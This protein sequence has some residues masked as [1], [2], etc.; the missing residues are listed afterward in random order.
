MGLESFFTLAEKAGFETIKSQQEK[1]GLSVILG[2]CGV[3]L[4]E[5]THFYTA[6]AREGNLH[7]LAFTQED[8]SNLEAPISLFSPEATY[9]IGSILSVIE[10]PDMP[11]RY[12]ESTKLKV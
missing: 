6:F 2:G 12:L 8:K 10:R 4:E 9:M 11:Q 1:L 7:G 5:L 3:T